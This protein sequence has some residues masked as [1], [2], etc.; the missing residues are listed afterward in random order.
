MV[1][2]KYLTFLHLKKNILQFEITIKVAIQEKSKC[3]IL[4]LKVNRGV[5]LNV[6]I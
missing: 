2:L 1:N 6:V 5:N 3:F 4:E